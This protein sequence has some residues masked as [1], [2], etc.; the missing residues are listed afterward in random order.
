MSLRNILNIIK[1][2]AC[3]PPTART[4]RS[5]PNFVY[6]NFKLPREHNNEK[7]I[8]IMNVNVFCI[9][10]LLNS[11]SS[12]S[13]SVP[14]PDYNFCFR[15]SVP[16]CKH[17]VRTPH[18]AD[19]HR[20]KHCKHPVKRPLV[21]TLKHLVKRAHNYVCVCRYRSDAECAYGSADAAHRT[22]KH[23]V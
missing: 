10:F 19:K 14:I 7:K 23:S 22:H 3:Q 6:I 11:A 8:I 17:P 5:I 16:P 15:K 12:S 13:P 21:N 9:S 2:T 4:D 18:Y 20:R 1:R